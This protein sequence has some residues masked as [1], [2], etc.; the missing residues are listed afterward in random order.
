MS[1]K[2]KDRKGTLFIRGGAFTVPKNIR[3]PKYISTPLQKELEKI[4]STNTSPERISRF[5]TN[6]ITKAAKGK[7]GTASR[8]LKE[9]AKPVSVKVSEG[10][11]KLVDAPTGGVSAPEGSMIPVTESLTWK[12]VSGR[13]NLYTAKEYKVSFT[14][15]NTSG[16]WMRDISRT[17]GTSVVKVSDTTEQYKFGNP[18]RPNLLIT[19]GANQKKQVMINPVHFGFTAQE[20][21]PLFS[22]AALDTSKIHEQKAYGAISNLTSHLTITSLNRYIPMYVKVH[23]LALTNPSLTVSEAFLQGTNATTVSQANA[24]MPL[25]TQQTIAVSND[26]YSD[27]D[28]DPQ[29]KGVLSSDAFTANFHRVQ[30][31][32]V[33]LSAGDRLKIKYDHLFGSGM[34]LDSLYSVVKDTANYSSTFPITFVVML[35]VYGEEVD[36]YNASTISEVIKASA[37]VA[38]QLEMSRSRKGVRPL[39]SSVNQQNQ[40]G[41]DAGWFA[42]SYAVKVYT[43]SPVRAQFRRWYDVYQ[44]LDVTYKVPVMSDA[45]EQDA[46]RVT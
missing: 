17:N 10:I 40:S 1:K 30:T 26:F 20:V 6:L 9:L 15:G 12:Q 21:T 28:V 29:S 33:K 8:I 42:S 11:A 27:V 45:S 32:S 41:T 23:L 44:N 2:K 3:V 39:L 35:E 38:F 18:V 25:Y 34:S 4:I 16:R 24:A 14:A 46:G 13:N 22:L 36:V 7:S 37:P 31:K 43:K 19:A 5:I